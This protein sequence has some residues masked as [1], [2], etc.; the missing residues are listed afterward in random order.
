MKIKLFYFLLSLLFFSLFLTACSDKPGKYDTFA[1]C[2]FEKG[3]KM[4]GTEWCSHCQS[5]KKMFGKSFKYI[6]YIDCDKDTNECLKNGVKGYP[7]WIIDGEKY[8]GEQP[9]QR[10]ASLTDCKLVQD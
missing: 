5:Q 8:T 10:L 1:T 4:Y 2:L 9:L 6:D 7:T 3:A